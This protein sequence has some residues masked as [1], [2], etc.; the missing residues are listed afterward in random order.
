[1]WFFGSWGVQDIHARTI[2]GDE[3]ATWLAAG[4]F[5]LNLQQKNT[6][7]EFN[8][9][10]DNKLKWGRTRLNR[11]QQDNGSL[12]DQLGPNY[13]FFAS[14][15]QILG[16]LMLTA[17]VGIYECIYELTPRG[18]KVD[19]LSGHN[20]GTDRTYFKNPLKLLYGSDTY[21]YTDRD[22]WTATFAGNYFQEK[23]IG[24]DHEIRF[25]VDYTEAKTT[26]QTLFPNQRTLNVSNYGEPTSSLG[27][28]LMPDSM[29]D[30]NLQP[31]FFLCR[32]HDHVRQADR[33]HRPQA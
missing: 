6:T 33:Q 21:F 16:N 5:K 30:I 2:V 12:R 26:S 32:R 10:S 14:A 13:Y 19:P 28:W 1:M 25:G 3:D 9:S 17:K 4:Y 29:Y 8:F 11:A 15:Q 18:S 23:F 22:E 27:V 24:G 20:L 7:A 31:H